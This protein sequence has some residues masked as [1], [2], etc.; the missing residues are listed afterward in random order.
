[1]MDKREIL[2]LVVRSERVVGIEDAMALRALVVEAY[3]PELCGPVPTFTS[4]RAAMGREM[5]GRMMVGKQ[6]ADALA[7]AP[8][9]TSIGQALKLVEDA[10]RVALGADQGRGSMALIPLRAAVDA[11]D[12]AL[13]APEV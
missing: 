4:T 2:D 10:A 8:V 5:R 13:V 11:L 1:M 9:I 12:A 7:A 3:L 6:I